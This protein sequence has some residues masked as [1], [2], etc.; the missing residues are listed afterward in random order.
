[1]IKYHHHPADYSGQDQSAAWIRLVYLGNL[2]AYL[3]EQEDKN[4]KGLLQLDPN[5]ENYFTY[6]DLEITELLDGIG[7]EIQEQK[8]YFRLFEI[9]SL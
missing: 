8:E 4:I 5:F 7:N 9:G 3:L 6:S 2:L 1:M